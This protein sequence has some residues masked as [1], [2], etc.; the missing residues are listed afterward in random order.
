[1]TYTKRDFGTD[2]RIEMQKGF[3]VDRLSQWAYVTYLDH[4]SELECGLYDK[5]MD[6]VVMQ[7]GDEF[8]LTEEQLRALAD[9][10][11]DEPDQAT[12]R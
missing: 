8:H 1:M 7:E 9:S 4:A 11:L 3:D 6:V 2:L 5:I 10:L 12:C